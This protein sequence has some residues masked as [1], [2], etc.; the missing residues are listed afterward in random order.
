MDRVGGTMTVSV[1]STFVDYCRKLKGGLVSL[2][3][4]LS[5]S[6]PYLFNVNPNSLR[7]EVT[8]QYPDP[9]SSKT[10]DDLPPRTRGLLHNQIDQCIGCHECAKV[11]P[12]QCIQIES[13]RLVETQKEWVSIFDIDHSKCLFCGLCVD[14]CP[15]N[16]L[17][18]TKRY[19]GATGAKNELVESFGKGEAPRRGDYL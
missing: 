10:V 11:C 8:E 16:S 5:A 4:A 2:C 7:K 13:E 9:V 14:V 19:E 1:F 18:H 6:I 17:T 3:R 15:T 12:V